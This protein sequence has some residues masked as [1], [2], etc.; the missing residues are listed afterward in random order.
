MNILKAS[1]QWATRPAD[2]RFTTLASLREAV[3]G[4]RVRSRST[5]IDLD[6]IET[7]V[8]AATGKLIVNHT[9]NPAEPSHWALRQFAGLLKAP[10]AYLSTLPPHLVS[11]CLNHGIKSQPREAV[12]FMVTAADG[13][14]DTLQAVTS[15]T[16]GRIWDA[17]V[18]DAVQRINDRTGGR[19][20]NPKAYAHKGAPNGFKTIDTS[21]TEPAGLYASDRD[22]FMFMIDGGSLLDAGPRAQLN[23]GFIVWNSEVGARTCGLMT[24]MF[25]VC[26]GNNII[27]GAQDVNQVLIR[28][29]KGAPTRFDNDSTPALLS[30]VNRKAGDD[31]AMIRRAVIWRL[32]TDEDKFDSFIAPFKFTRGE[33]DNARK[34]AKLEEGQCETLWDLIQGFTAYAR[35]FDYMDARIDLERRGSA[36]LKV[37][38]NN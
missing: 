24:F 38:E 13:G 35:G 15:P 32:P 31:E 29:S 11:D 20:Y 4:R 9:I 17:D 25:N 3:H 28:H 18:V 27:F 19:F 16:Y 12:K 6:K 14:P 2:Q 23:R 5:D 10:G 7:T 22:V 33:I 30:F 36:L 26:C 37:V 1:H 34:M 21:R 8:D